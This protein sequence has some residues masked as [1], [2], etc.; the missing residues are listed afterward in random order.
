MFL[1]ELK[2]N[3]TRLE[4]IGLLRSAERIHAVIMKSI[5]GTRPLWRLDDRYEGKVIYVVSSQTP[6]F[7]GFIEQYGWP[8][9]AYEDTIRTVDMSKLLDATIP[10]SRWYF[11]T[12]V[13]PT[14]R[15][16][17]ND[18]PLIREEA[19]EWLARKLAV[20]ATIEDG[21]LKPGAWYRSV[22]TKGG[23]RVTIRKQPYMGRLTVNDQTT[24]NSLLTTGIGHGKAY[25]CGL[26]TLAPAGKE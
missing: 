13:N 17:G 9:R 18:V 10:G 20:G 24:M 3:E 11:Q 23:H 14:V 5:P 1:T 16:R 19:D 2:V 8:R 21:T 22:F 6:D 15:K 7:T 25:G 4:S 12:T 26:L